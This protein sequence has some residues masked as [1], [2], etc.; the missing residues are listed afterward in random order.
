MKIDFP[1]T[2]FQISYNLRRTDPRLTDCPPGLGRPTS[3]R[4]RQNSSSSS[5]PKS[6]TYQVD[7]RD[8][9]RGFYGNVVE[10]AQFTAGPQLAE[11]E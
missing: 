8:P 9:W 10:T 3:C 11:Y 6:S 4:P 1:K 7:S 2:N 5:M